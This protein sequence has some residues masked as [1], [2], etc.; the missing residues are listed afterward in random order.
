MA[1]L[2]SL[3]TEPENLSFFA[4]SFPSPPHAGKWIIV[5]YLLLMMCTARLMQTYPHPKPVLWINVAAGCNRL[6]AY[7]QGETVL[8]TVNLLAAFCA[9]ISKKLQ[10]FEINTARRWL[11]SD[12]EPARRI[13]AVAAR[14]RLAGGGAAAHGKTENRCE[15]LA[16]IAG[17][18]CRSAR[19]GQS[20]ASLA[21][22]CRHGHA[23]ASDDGL[24]TFAARRTCECRLPELNRMRLA[25]LPERGINVPAE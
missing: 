21:R 6:S 10:T 4:S 8:G 20:L 1:Q 7:T 14:C 18:V 25:R 19:V 12:A 16:L 24:R 23:G 3:R 13:A 17:R 9:A 15:F 22:E 11:T 5:C 2:P